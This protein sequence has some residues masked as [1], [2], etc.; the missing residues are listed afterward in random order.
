MKTLQKTALFWDVDRAK[1]DPDTSAE[2]IIKRVLAFGDVDDV[3]FALTKYGASRLAEVA[4]HMRG[5]DKKSRNFWN[6]Y[7]AHA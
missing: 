1:L 2:F 3:R 7:F 6:V 5:L 4:S